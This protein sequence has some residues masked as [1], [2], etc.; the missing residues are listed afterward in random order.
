MGPAP[1]RSH[2]KGET[3]KSADDE[4]EPSFSAGTLQP[5]P[6]SDHLVL[7]FQAEI[8]R[9]ECSKS[10][11]WRMCGGLAES[12]LGPLN[13]ATSLLTWLGKGLVRG[14]SNWCQGQACSGIRYSPL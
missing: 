5:C 2:P 4:W 9:W 1:G 12:P 11:G 6:V 14:C 7:L 10:E 8:P 13:R 3:L